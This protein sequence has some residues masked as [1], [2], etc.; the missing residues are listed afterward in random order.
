MTK[1][2]A[3]RTR[4][5]VQGL[6][7]HAGLPVPFW[8]THGRHAGWTAGRLI[9]RRGSRRDDG[10]GIRTTVFLK[11]CPL[12]CA[13]CHDPEGESAG[14]ELALILQKCI[15]CLPTINDDRMLEDIAL[16]LREI[17]TLTGVRLLPHHDFARSKYGAI[18]LE[19]SMPLLKRPSPEKMRELRSQVSRHGITVLD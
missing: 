6:H 15:P 2:V 8:Q 1:S 11:G 16:F 4:Q 3:Q 19:D 13:W 17:P 9:H 14:P 10:P 12:R 5:L 18:G 7:A